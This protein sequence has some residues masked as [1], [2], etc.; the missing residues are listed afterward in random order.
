MKKRFIVGVTTSVLGLVG[1][2]VWK[3]LQKLD[4]QQ[5]FH[6]VYASYFMHE[7]VLEYAVVDEVVIEGEALQQL[8]QRA[9]HMTLEKKARVVNAQYEIALH[10]LKGMIVY[11]SIGSAR[12]IAVNG[13]TYK[14]VNGERFYEAVRELMQ[15]GSAE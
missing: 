3:G 12:A 15:K 7:D 14:V 5:P 10:S 8:L 4:A 1:A 9:D 6:E 2:G 13:I 11:V